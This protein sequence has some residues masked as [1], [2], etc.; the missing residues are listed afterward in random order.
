MG[1]AYD[2]DL[3]AS[4]TYYANVEPGYSDTLILEVNGSDVTLILYGFVIKYLMKI[5]ENYFGEYTHFQTFEEFS[6]KNMDQLNSTEFTHLKTDIDL[7]VLIY[8]YVNNG[9]IIL[10]ANI[11][12]AE[13]NVLLNFASFDIDVR[14]TNYYMGMH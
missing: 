13:A 9:S 1:R 14:F 10:P 12:S 8:V 7:D 2:F 5:R 6:Q 11:Y 4:Y 3:K